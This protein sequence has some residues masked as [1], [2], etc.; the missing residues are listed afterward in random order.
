MIAFLFSFVAFIF[1]LV[2]FLIIHHCETYSMTK[3]KM[4]LKPKPK[5]KLKPKLLAIMA[6]AI[7]I[8]FTMLAL[9]PEKS[10]AF[11]RNW[12][13]VEPDAE[14]KV[15]VRDWN[16]RVY[17]WTPASNED[18]AC[19]FIGSEAGPNVHCFEKSDAARQAYERPIED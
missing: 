3:P 11:F 17:E 2:A 5:M 12:T 6:I 8:I 13:T 19:M 10:E 4:K 15:E 14:Y 18:I 9:W 16:L 7:L 1:P